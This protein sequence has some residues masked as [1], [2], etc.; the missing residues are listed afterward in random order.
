MVVVVVVV[1]A[2]IIPTHPTWSPCTHTCTQ[3]HPPPPHTQED[4]ILVDAHRR[5]GNKWTEISKIFGDRWVGERDF[6]GT[7]GSVRGAAPNPCC[8]D[9]KECIR[10]RRG[11][12]NKLSSL[13]L[14]CPHC[15][16]DNAVKNR[17]HALARKHPSLG[18]EQAEDSDGEGGPR[19][20][21]RRTTRGAKQAEEEEEDGGLGSEEG[22]HHSLQVGGVAGWLGSAGWE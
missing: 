9:T 12:L 11:K 20:K 7:G 8:E 16:T 4:A 2:N 1:M 14:V 6:G 15:R 3:T 18:R 17:W 5:L 10:D 21:R 22:R 19:R 13:V